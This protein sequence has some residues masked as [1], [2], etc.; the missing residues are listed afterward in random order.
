MFPNNDM[1][2]GNNK[3]SSKM[4]QQHLSSKEEEEEEEEDLIIWGRYIVAAVGS[5]GLMLWLPG[6][7]SNKPLHLLPSYVAKAL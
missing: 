7:K 5:C 3:V 4:T 1:G 2:R 6:V